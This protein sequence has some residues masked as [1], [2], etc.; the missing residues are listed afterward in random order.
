L[1]VL[2]KKVNSKLKTAKEKLKP[3]ERMALERLMAEGYRQEARVDK[4]I[5]KDWEG[6]DTV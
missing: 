2:M 3:R 1:K 4:K 6:A 5:S